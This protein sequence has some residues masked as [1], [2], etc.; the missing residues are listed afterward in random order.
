[1]ALSFSFAVLVDFD[2]FLSLFIFIS[3]CVDT[4]VAQ[5]RMGQIQVRTRTKPEKNAV[6][7]LKVVYCTQSAPGV[8]P[9]SCKVGCQH[10]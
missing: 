8:Y 7:H 9:K 3:P 5:R 1:M 10:Q 2:F 4:T 6:V